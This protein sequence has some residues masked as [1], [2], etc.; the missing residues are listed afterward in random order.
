MLTQAKK[1]MKQTS[2]KQTGK[3]LKY[4]KWNWNITA[5]RYELHQQCK[6]GQKRRIFIVVP[7]VKTK[8]REK[9]KQGKKHENG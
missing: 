6:K 4:K 8:M 1:K 3:E 2:N 7:Q 5:D 9:G